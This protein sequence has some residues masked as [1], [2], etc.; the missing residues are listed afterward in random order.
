MTI[1]ERPCPQCAVPRTFR[2]WGGRSLCA[3]CRCQWSNREPRHC[4][5][6]D[7]T[8]PGAAHFTTEELVRLRIYRAAFAH[9][10]YTDW[11]SSNDA[12]RIGAAS[13]QME[14]GVPPCQTC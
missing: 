12:H 14:G 11:P 8:E 1:Q 10:L 4:L 2:L 5:R 7:E 9:S 3:N 6:G 13:Y